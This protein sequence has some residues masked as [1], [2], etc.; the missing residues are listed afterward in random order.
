[1]SKYRVPLRREEILE[2]FLAMLHDGYSKREITEIL[3]E[4]INIRRREQGEEW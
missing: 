4:A 3:D 1:M 2:A